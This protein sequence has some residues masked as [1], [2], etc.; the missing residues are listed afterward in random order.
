MRVPTPWAFVA[1]AWLALSTGVAIGFIAARQGETNSPPLSRA[2]VSAAA[3]GTTAPA[4]ADPTVEAQATA[5]P[6]SAIVPEP[7]ATPRQILIPAATPAPAT[8]TVSPS[9]AGPEPPPN[10]SSQQVIAAAQ[11]RF[12]PCLQAHSFSSYIGGAVYLGARTWRVESLQVEGGHRVFDGL[13]NESSGV[14]VVANAPGG[15]PR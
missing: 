11:G 2:S 7:T 5:T 12:G 9:P 13:F 6:E 15:C 14:W 8:P 1:V 3:T 10:L 4:A